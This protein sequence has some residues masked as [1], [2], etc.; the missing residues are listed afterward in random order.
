MA[1]IAQ[2]KL[3]SWEKIDASS[4]LDRLRFVLESIPDEALMRKLE[5]A[6]GHGRNDYP[7]RPVWNSILAGIVFEHVSIASLRRELLR[8]GQLRGL[9]GFDPFLGGNAVPPDWVY[10]RF[11]KSLFRFEDEINAMFDELVE[12]LRA[13]LPGLG[14]HLAIDGKAIHSAGKHTDKPPDGRRDADADWG[15]K[16]YKGKRKDG[17][18]WEKTKRWFGFKL[19]LIVDAEHELPVAFDMTRASTNDT[20]MLNP[21]LEKLSKTHPK[22]VENARDI[23]ADKGYDSEKNN[24]VPFE[25]Y[26]IKPLIDIR[27]M[28]RDGETTRPLFPDKADSIV[29]DE[30]GAI[31]CVSEDPRDAGETRTL[32]M[33]FYGF[34]KDRMTL[35]YRCPAAAY[36]LD[37]PERGRCGAS[38][39]G[40]TVRVPLDMDRRLFVPIPRDSPKWKRLYKR[41]TAAERVNSR[42]DVSFGFERHFIRGLKKMKVRAGLALIV[43]LAMAVGSIEAGQKEKMRSLVWSVKK[44]KA[45]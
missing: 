34:E 37:C 14:K 27:H 12:T 3:F 38:E 35:K 28:W 6:R 33:A 20:V 19:H 44:P 15:T 45:A 18:V 13:L 1:I 31:H 32:P 26:A 5:S 4:D 39:Y 7:I 17:T 30:D 23:A 8:N 9:C 11:L 36:G 22:I 10:T 43:M 16:T 24:R 21:M 2:T 40:R 29:Y 25:K 42:L 41:R